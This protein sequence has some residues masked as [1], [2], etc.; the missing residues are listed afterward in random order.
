MLITMKRRKYTKQLRSENDPRLNIFF[1]LRSEQI[2]NKK[3]NPR[4]YIGVE[5]F[6]R[7][8]QR[9]ALAQ[10]LLLEVEIQITPNHR[11]NLCLKGRDIVNNVPHKLVTKS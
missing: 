5:P 8:Q 3:I 11:M 1:C 10:K 6:L 2:D 9:P 7:H 4:N